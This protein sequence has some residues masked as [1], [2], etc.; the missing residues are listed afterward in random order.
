[1][2]SAVGR[3]CQLIHMNIKTVQLSPLYTNIAVS[4]IKNV[5]GF[6]IYDFFIYDFFVFLQ[7]RSSS[8]FTK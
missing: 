5:D 3:R 1:M 7:D 6:F 8:I 2:I 4:R